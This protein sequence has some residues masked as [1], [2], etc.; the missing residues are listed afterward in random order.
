MLPDWVLARAARRRGGAHLTL[1][2]SVLWIINKFLFLSRHRTIHFYEWGAF[3]ARTS[4]F[5]PF[6]IQKGSLKPGSGILVMF[7]GLNV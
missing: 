4:L 6:V 1:P 2:A 5:Y 7:D 3:L